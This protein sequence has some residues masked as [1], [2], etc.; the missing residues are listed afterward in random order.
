MK[1]NKLLLV[2]ALALVL[3]AGSSTHIDP[4][5]RQLLSVETLRRWEFDDGLADWRAMHDSVISADNG[6]LKIICTGRDPYI[7]SPGVNVTGPVSVRLRMKSAMGQSGQIFWTTEDSSGFSEDRSAHFKIAKDNQWHIYTVDLVTDQVI[8]RIRL[9]PGQSNGMVYMDCL[10]L[11]RNNLHPLEI[12]EIRSDS[13]VI[14]LTLKNNAQHKL[15]FTL[16]TESG[17]IGPGR[18]K[19]IALNV[20]D[21]PRFEPYPIVIKTVGL[22][23]VVRAVHLYRPTVKTDWVQQ[24]TKNLTLRVA[25]DG[26]GAEIL[27]GDKVVAIMNPLVQIGNRVPKLVQA[28]SDE[29]IAFI[30]QGTK[31][32]LR[33]KDSEISA[34]IESRQKVEGPV[35]RVLG[36]LEQGLF[37]GLEYLGRQEQSSS[38]LDIDTPEHIR[39][40]PDLLKI[41][42]PLM[43]CVTDR[44]AAAM[45][46]DD[47]AIQPVLPVPNFFDGS[48]DHRMSLKANKIDAAIRVCNDRS[49]EESI[50]WAV[51]RRGLP[52]LPPRPR[53]SQQQQKLCLEAFEGPLQG[54]GGWGH[55]VQDRWPR[56]P[57]AD[58]ASTIWR[59]SGRIPELSGIVPGGAHI[60]NIAIYFVTGRTEQWLNEQKGRIHQLISAQHSDGSFRYSGKYQRGHF[61]D[62]ASGYCAEKAFRLLDY[63]RITGDEQALK[64]GLM[65]LEY[66]KR[67][68]TPRGAQTWELSLHTPDILASGYLVW[69]YVLGYE[70]TANSDYI[71][72]ARRWAL[73]GIP[74]VYLWANKPVMKYAT[75]PVYGATNWRG[76]NWMGLP[77]QWCGLTYAYALDLL[78]LH[79]NT[80]EW[81]RLSEGI[82]IAAEQM[83]YVSGDS[84]GCLPDSW[85]LQSQCPQPYDINPCVLVNLR[86]RLDG[87]VD[88]TAVATDGKFRVVAPFPVD[89]SG[90]KAIIQGQKGLLYQILVNGTRIFN[91]RSQGRD[92]IALEPSNLLKLE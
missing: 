14:G 87:D 2:M 68:R 10:E 35:L 3:T 16:N 74:F 32:A 59:L 64:S 5:G 88:S 61:E 80:L 44:G 24:S 62:T 29:S 48:D 30:G 65:T 4:Y 91:V 89:I 37:A 67:F 54:P 63:A 66:M 55:C 71:T 23:D 85:D 17:R 18:T 1:K 40:E 19:R 56:R 52:D 53:N 46:W 11:I 6:I 83:Q 9:D 26:S 76:Q 39:F 27:S 31:I 41:T 90:D 69:A 72:Q 75:V 7:H 42:M 33:I 43:A 70:L 92:V 50:L 82:L 60:P 8:T 21:G 25:V 84:I 13:S 22:S 77:V 79:D 15:N 45:M 58:H 12:L 57:F 20:K 86:R 38:S 49:L 34:R 47:M 78:A 51:K 36:S 28:E 81:R 73:S